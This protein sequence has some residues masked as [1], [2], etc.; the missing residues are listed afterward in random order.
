MD[1]ATRLKEL[2]RYHILDTPA[3]QGFND[4]V[5]LASQIC[6]TPIA[7]ISFVD[8]DR[9]WFKAKTGFDKSETPLSQ[10]VCRLAIQQPGL[11]IIPD[12]SVDP[13]TW[14][15]TLVSEDP[16]IRFYAGARLET[17]EGAALGSLC[18]IDTDARPE[19]LKPGQ[20]AALEALSRLVMMLMEMRNSHRKQGAELATT[21]GALRQSQKMEA[22]GQLT[23][24]I[25]HD[26]NNL[27]TGIIGSVDIVGRRVAANRFDD[28]PRFLNAAS[29]AA[30]KAAGLTNRLLAFARRQSLDS[31][32][33]D[34]NALVGSMEDLLRR[35]LG[36]EVG[37]QVERAEC[38][39]PAM[40][41]AH[42]LENAV[43]NLAINARDAMPSG[44]RLT[45]ETGNTYL[46]KNYA[47]D[48]DELSAGDY[49]VIS[50]SDTGTGMPPDVVAQAF[51]P[52]YTTKPIGAGTGLG[53]S[54]VY[55]F[56]KQSKGHVGIYSEVGEGTTIRLYVPRALTEAR[57]LIQDDR[58]SPQ[59]KGESIL[60]VEDDATVR[61]LITS[62]LEELGYQFMESGD[63]IAAIK[64]LQSGAVIDLLITDVG[65]PVTN[66]RQLAEMARQLRPG[67]KVLFVTG[68]AEMAAV[69]GGFLAEGMDM[70]TKP[71]ALEAFGS[72]VK[73]MI[74]RQP[75]A[76]ALLH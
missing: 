52:F 75:V 4:I 73:E 60:V 30:H 40:L 43:L 54:M 58:I 66:G 33:T 32:P 44:G 64:L 45:I 56:I 2:E 39:W 53:L 15:N 10:S 6:G 72:K 51:D 25:A 21:Q 9:Q 13:R 29:T 16:N 11:F 18:V 38:L 22:I 8:H 41:D 49:V 50:V 69:R 14:H 37:L 61:L 24:G 28:V 5:L 55:G 36:K 17:P 59:G 34:I 76:R 71:F 47:K 3:E 67:L 48:Q 26:F 1:E 7:L 57:Q 42:Q 62:V 65:L 12:L 20:A 19:G 63:A 70:M 31:K 27:L 23:G 74:G 46:D 35:T 68:Y